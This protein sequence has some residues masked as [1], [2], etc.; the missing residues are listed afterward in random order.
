MLKIKLLVSY[1]PCS[2]ITTSRVTN[3]IMLSWSADCKLFS[4]SLQLTV[5]PVIQLKQQYKWIPL[6]K[7]SVMRNGIA[8]IPCPRSATAKLTRNMLL[9][10]RSDSL[11]LT[12]PITSRLPTSDNAITTSMTTRVNISPSVMLPV[13][14]RAEVV[15]VVEDVLT[16]P[17]CVDILMEDLT[18][19]NSAAKT[20]SYHF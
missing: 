19:D 10:V 13:P 6:L 8:M 20:T 14:T 15:G 2:S 3:R 18:D 9:G 7:I 1:T 12:A 16:F 11:I 17:I 4:S 5:C